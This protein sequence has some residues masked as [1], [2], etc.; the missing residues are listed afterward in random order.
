MK[1]IILILS[2]IVISLLFIYTGIPK[3]LFN[4]SNLISKFYYKNTFL[5][6]ILDFLFVLL[7]FIIAFKLSNVFHIVKNPLL[8]RVLFMSII[9]IV[10]DLFFAMLIKNNF[11]KNSDFIN[12]FKDWIKEAGFMG[13]IWDLIY[14]NSIVVVDYYLYNNYYKNKIQKVEDYIWIIL[15]IIILYQYLTN[16]KLKN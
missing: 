14:L 2:F 5:A 9:V 3:F 8:N 4:N 10:L 7:Y 11:F 13:I 12:F 16:I 1:I 15:T 6:L